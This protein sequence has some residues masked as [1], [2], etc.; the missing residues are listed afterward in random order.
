MAMWESSVAG[1]GLVGIEPGGVAIGVGSCPLSSNRVVSFAA[2]GVGGAKY[3]S[4]KRISLN[5]SARA[6]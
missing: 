6:R 3:Q 5:S 2:I 4:V 1:A